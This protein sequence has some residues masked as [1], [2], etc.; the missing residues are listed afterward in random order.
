[1]GEPSCTSPSVLILWRGSL[2][3]HVV[4]ADQKE[5]LTNILHV[6]LQVANLLGT[7][8]ETHQWY[9]HRFS[10]Y[11]QTRTALIPYLL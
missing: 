1:M 5:S 10:D 3:L 4:L 6:L 7:A 9:V 8:L 11:P 2:Y